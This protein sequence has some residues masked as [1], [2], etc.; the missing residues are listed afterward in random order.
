MG[1]CKIPV[2]PNTFLVYLKRVWEL[3]GFKFC[4]CF[5][6]IRHCLVQTHHDTGLCLQRLMTAS[7]HRSDAFV[8][9]YGYPDFL[10]LL[11]EQKRLID[12]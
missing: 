4:G 10:G 12:A 3:F 5:G 7:G 6:D 11:A 2:G 9:S 1:F 8:K